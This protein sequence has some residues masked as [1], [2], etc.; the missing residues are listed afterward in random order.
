[1]MRVTRRAHGMSLIE[2]MIVV[3]ILAV[4]A[5]IAVPSYRRYLLRAQRADATTE[6]LRVRSAQEKYF[7]QN[8][9]YAT[10]DEFDD[11][12]NAGGLG[13]TGTSEHGY[14]LIDLPIATVTTFTVRARATAGQI[15]DSTCQTF[16][17]DELGVRTATDAGGADMT[18]TC[19]R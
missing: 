7:L 14:Y 6:L 17:V 4:I 19:W 12:K 1:M 8:N 3:V 18:A 15:E 9:R 16:T 13:F 2:L 5:T 10:T 11:P